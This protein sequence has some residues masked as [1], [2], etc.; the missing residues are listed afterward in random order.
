M[1]IDS[2]LFK[3]TCNAIYSALDGSEGLASSE[4]LELKT[5]DNI[6]FL[7]VANEEY[8][9]SV[10]FE[11]DHVEEF[12]ATVNAH[13]FLKLMMSITTDTLEL[14][15]KDNYV[16]IKANGNYKIP[17]IFKD[18]SLYSLPKIII[19]N[20]TVEMNIE[21]NVLE[22]IL[23]YNSRELAKSSYASPV[24]KMYYIDQE[25]CITFTNGACVNSFTL[26]KPIKV[27]L[28][29]KLVKLFKL[30]KNDTIHFSLGYDAL[31]NDIIQTK[32]CFESNTMKL[33]AITGC[34]DTLLNSVPVKAIRNRA[35]KSYPHTI[36][37]NRNNLLDA[38]N[39]LL[40][41]TPA[42]SSCSVN[43]FELNNQQIVIYDNRKE[44]TETLLL[45]EGSHLSSDKYS[46]HLDLL[47]LKSILDKCNEQFITINFG[48]NTAIVIVRNQ[49]LNVIPECNA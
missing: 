11:L 32:V 5:Q 48:D 37:L 25:G 41:F 14:N 46:M 31:S 40:L 19:D 17:L 3:N 15:I 10:K 47:Y 16:A 44:N 27:L 18:N 45:Q 20:K 42:T 24:Q 1:I 9:T 26:E 30:F 12:H 39:R 2:K 21:G 38:I 28:N 29:N 8:Y 7:N 36:V 4:I 49:I 13:L 6:L 43:L 23:N 33:V 34:D 35:T 22:S